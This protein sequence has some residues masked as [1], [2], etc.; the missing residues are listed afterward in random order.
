MKRR[1]WL[2][3]NRAISS[4]FLTPLLAKTTLTP[5]QITVMSMVSG[6]LA[7]IFLS[8]GTYESGIWGVIFYEF[9]C[10]LDNSDGDIARLK[11]MQ[12]ELG[13]KLDILCDVVTDGALF[14]GIFLGAYKFGIPGPLALLFWLTLFGLGAHYAIV[15]IEK[16]KGFGPAQFGQ[17]NPEGEERDSLISEMM[18]AASEGEISLAVL[19][20]G[21]LGLIYWLAWLSPVYMN[22]IWIMNLAINFRW[23][24]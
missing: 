4:R 19:A 21:F 2:W 20:L 13:A 18:N 14:I 3:I 5:N 16:K 12:T 24:K 6:I 10:L 23:I 9:A 15:L 1:P 17:P 11:N 7:G 8:L 22:A